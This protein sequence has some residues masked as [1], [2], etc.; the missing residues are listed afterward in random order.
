MDFP[1]LPDWQ[2]IRKSAHYP[3]LLSYPMVGYEVKLEN[4]RFTRRILGVV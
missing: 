2:G 3:T 4:I 1:R